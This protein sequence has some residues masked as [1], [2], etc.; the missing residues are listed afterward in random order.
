MKNLSFAV[1]ASVG[2]LVALELLGRVGSTVHRDI[3][4]KQDTTPEQWLIH[5]PTVGWEKKP[6]YEGSVGLADREFD[7]EG[8]FAVDSDQVAASSGKKKVVFVGDSN[9]FGWGVPTAASFVE[10]AENLLT[11]VDAINLG[12]VGYTSY[13]GRITLEKQLPLLKPDL[14]VVSFNFNDRRYVLQ[15]EA[16]D[17][18]EEFQRVYQSSR[19]AA[20][21]IAG[22]VEMSHFYRGLRLFMRKVGLAPGPVTEID[23]VGLNPRVDEDSYR[24]NLSQIAAETKR[25]GIP[26]LFVLLRDDPLLSDHL[27]RG[28]ASLAERDY[29]MAIAYLNA[30][31]RS[32]TM[33][34]EVARLY[35]AKAY[36][37]KGD[38]AK[39]AEAAVSRSVYRSFSGGTL[40]RL[41]TDYNDIMRE[42]A[43]GSHVALLDGAKVLEEQPSAFIDFCHFNADGHRRLGE[44]LAV[45]IS[46]ILAIEPANKLP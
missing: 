19:S 35:L 8:Y 11:D 20:A 43:A 32:D 28:I 3:A 4:W 31:V 36:E 46:E 42:V 2:V 18:P 45:R 23:V 7:A 41:D 14:V 38:K 34:S 40:I 39:A 13:Q 12:V 30:T 26:V 15:P 27:K 25:L 37:A 10:V 44:A 24:R 33:F 17:G 22:F 9:T 16:V 21:S 29:D 6:G 1:L 5:S